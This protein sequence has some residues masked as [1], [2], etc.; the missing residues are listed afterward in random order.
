MLMLEAIGGKRFPTLANLLSSSIPT[1]ELGGPIAVRTAPEHQ[2]VRP[3]GLVVALLECLLCN[4]TSNLK[5]FLKTSN[6]VRNLVTTMSYHEELITPSTAPRSSTVHAISLSAHFTTHRARRPS[7]GRSSATRRS[8]RAIALL[9]V[10]RLHPRLPAPPAPPFARATHRP[11][12]NKPLVLLSAGVAVVTRMRNAATTT[13]TVGRAGAAGHRAA[14]A[15]HAAL[16]ARRRSGT[17]SRATSASSS[18][19]SPPPMARRSAHSRR[20]A[21]CAR[22]SSSCPSSRRRAR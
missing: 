14:L 10:L 8:A 18:P 6:G 20:A 7:S 12:R 19:T 17:R 2:R 1:I 9:R 13:L 3:V 5:P 16:W 4:A 11:T 22:S 15:A 21:R